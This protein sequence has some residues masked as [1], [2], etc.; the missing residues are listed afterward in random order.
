METG[1]AL[2]AAR[3]ASDK[4]GRLSAHSSTDWMNGPIGFARSAPKSP[5]ATCATSDQSL[6]P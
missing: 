2:A 5:K 6:P 3:G 1:R 4:G